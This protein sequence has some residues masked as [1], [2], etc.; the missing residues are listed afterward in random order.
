MIQ[1]RKVLL[2]N[3]LLAAAFLFYL[4]ILDLV[5]IFVMKEQ[6]SIVN[7]LGLLIV[8]MP[9]AGAI[10]TCK[11]TTGSDSGAKRYIIIMASFAALA[12]LGFIEYL[13][14]AISFHT[15]LGGTI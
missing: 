6:E 9:F 14:V 8:V 10:L 1:K 13:W 12:A 7:Y 4:C 3:V 15:M 11:V 5:F 2:Y